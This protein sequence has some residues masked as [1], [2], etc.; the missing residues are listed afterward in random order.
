MQHKGYTHD[1]PIIVRDRSFDSNSVFGIA[2]W[3]KEAGLGV[4]G[5]PVQ[6]EFLQQIQLGFQTKWLGVR[7]L[8]APVQMLRGGREAGDRQAAYLRP[9]L[10]CVC[11]NKSVVSLTTYPTPVS[12]LCF[13]IVCPE[14]MS[15]SKS[16]AVLPNSA[17]ASICLTIL[18]IHSPGILEMPSGLVCGVIEPPG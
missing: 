14:C 2:S 9:Q 13:L 11:F 1:I 16:F 5:V 10:V 18:S 4:S 12:S 3:A 15:A 7:E 17:C 8:K 6:T